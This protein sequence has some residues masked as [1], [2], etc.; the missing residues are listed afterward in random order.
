M[1]KAIIKT[2]I[3]TIIGIRAILT[4]SPLLARTLKVAPNDEGI[5][6]I[7]PANRSIEMPLPIPFLS[8]SEPS[9]IT[10]IAPAVKQLTITT[11]DRT[12][13]SPVV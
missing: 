11:A 4:G 8:I 2:K 12:I 6:A 5:S 9:Q 3:T 1:M 7:I 10:S 13:E